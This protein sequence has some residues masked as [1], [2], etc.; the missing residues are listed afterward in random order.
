M[1]TALFVC[2]AL[3]ALPCA[4]IARAEPNPQP[5]NESDGC[6]QA[7]EVGPG[8]PGVVL[9][10]G[11]MSRPEWQ[12]W[13]NCDGT[14]E[15]GYC[16]RFGGVVDP[17]YGAFAEGF[18]GIGS[19]GSLRVYL[20]QIG[21][22]QGG[23]SELFVW[24]DDGGI[25]GSVL[26]VRPGVDFG[27]MAF[28]PDVSAHDVPLSCIVQG[29]F[30]V[31][32]QGNFQCEACQYYCAADEDGPGGNPWTCI[33]PGIGYPTGWQHPS[34]VWGDVQALGIGV[35]IALSSGVEELPEE[36]LYDQRTNWGRIKAL[37]GP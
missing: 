3:M 2:L 31:G 23:L 33:A 20:T 19:V 12:Y 37:F 14:F 21:Y 30:Y 7:S 36:S 35:Q 25:P 28:W 29:A 5:W 34:L 1:R 22:Y 17:Y 8:E 9:Y 13:E 11:V 32:Y 15:N 26:H 18:E 4:M 6:S 27:E 16:W 10:D 24:G